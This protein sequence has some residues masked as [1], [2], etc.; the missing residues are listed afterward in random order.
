MRRLLFLLIVGVG[1]CAILLSLGIWQ[2]RRLAWKEAILAEI[3][4]QIVA[5]AV[6]LDRLG[7]L[8][9]EAHRYRAVTVSG[10]TT[11][12]EALVISGQTMAG[13]GYEVISAFQTDTGRMILLDRGFVPE[14]A[15]TKE[16]P[17]VALSVT[18]NLAWPHDSD[19]YTPP[20][21]PK[22]HIFF[23]RDAGPIAQALGTEP[24][25]VIAREV[26]G[27]EPGITPVPVDTSAIPNNHLNYAITWFS[28][29]VVWAG[30]TVA[31]LWRIRRRAS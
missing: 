24:V 22:T 17:P 19:S 31:F 12:P 18:G 30:M 20:P 3:N 4:A 26:A 9:E 7:A 23:A 15:R 27:E 21:D 29:A 28:L 10:R 11:G 16:R 6:P 13:A 14:A 1:G 8:K 25:L 5:P 2:V